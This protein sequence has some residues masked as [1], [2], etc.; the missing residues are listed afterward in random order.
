MDD[1]TKATNSF[2]QDARHYAAEAAFVQDAKL[3][4][5]ERIRLLLQPHVKEIEIVYSMRAT[6]PPSR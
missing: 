5:E 4:M 3:K 6:V 2:I 1:R